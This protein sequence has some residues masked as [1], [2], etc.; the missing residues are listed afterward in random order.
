MTSLIW[1][2]TNVD[3]IKDVCLDI[4]VNMTVNDKVLIRD[5]A[6]DRSERFAVVS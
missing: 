3:I 5:L 4:K 6:F 2:K 1:G